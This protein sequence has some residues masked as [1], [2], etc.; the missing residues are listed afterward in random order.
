M[1]PD[2]QRGF[3]LLEVLIAF[4]IVAIALSA[5][6]KGTSFGLNA[7]GQSGRYEEALSRARS[8]LAA[9]GP[10][11]DR[12]VG[13]HTD[14]DGGGYRWS[15]DVHPFQTHDQPAAAGAAGGPALYA[16]TVTISWHDGKHVRSV[17]LASERLGTQAQ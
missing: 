9:V 7:V 5:L 11:V 6:I 16:V 4:A 15:L 17:A 8:H 12:L 3:T 1:R 13:S 14:D 2:A 10:D